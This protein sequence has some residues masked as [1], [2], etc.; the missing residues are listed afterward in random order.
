MEIIETRFNGKAWAPRI[1]T[2]NLRGA[3]RQESWAASVI[4][5]TAVRIAQEEVEPETRITIS[6]NEDI[7]KAR[8]TGCLLVQKMGFSG[9]RITLVITVISELARNILLYARS[10][11]VVLACMNS[12]AQL[13]VTA[14]DQGP[15]IENLPVVM[16]GGYSTSGGLGLGLCGLRRIVD[17][18]EVKTQPGKGTQVYVSIH[19]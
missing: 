11:E 12:G 4:A 17:E 8:Q 15:G 19:A 2:P 18:F 6:N 13:T 9:S 10:G 14:L 16:A 7:V 3:M 5:R 1:R